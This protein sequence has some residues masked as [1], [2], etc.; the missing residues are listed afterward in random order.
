M[1]E[2]ER[3]IVIVACVVA[4]FVVGNYPWVCDDA[5]ISLRYAD[6]LARGYGL[7]FNPGERVQGFTNPLWTLLLVPGAALGSYEPWAVG[8]GLACTIGLLH[9]LARLARREDFGVWG[10][11]FCLAAT[12][13]CEGFIQFQTSGLETSLVN[14]LVAA[15]LVAALAADA[16]HRGLAPICAALACLTRLD[17]ALL[18]APIVVVMSLDAPGGWRRGLQRAWLGSALAAGLVLAWLGFAAIYYGYPLPNTFYAKTGAPRGEVLELGLRYLADF[19]ILR[20]PTTLIMIVGLACVPWLWRP[21]TPDEPATRDQRLFGAAAL[22]GGLALVYVVWVG[23]D[24]MHGRFVASPALMLSIVAARRLSRSP[25]RRIY[26]VAL[27]LGA[28]LTSV[29]LRPD[30]GPTQITN[31]RKGWPERAID[32][33]AIERVEAL[34]PSLDPTL[35]THL[36]GQRFGEDPR[37]SWLDSY[38][39]TDAF[40]ARCPIVRADRA[41]HFERAIPLAY[42]RAR[43]DASLLSAGERRLRAGDPSLAEALAELRANPGWD[44]RHEQ[45]YAELELLTRGPVWDPDRLALIAKYTLSRPT[46]ADIAGVETT[47]R[48]GD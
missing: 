34:D 44:P 3:T 24:Y 4:F 13:L 28:A 18:T 35:A 25:R 41:G 5:T 33:A 2:R 39:L 10:L 20:A 11:G 26:L 43:G 7:V 16:R 19:A 8:L 14:L 37:I 21:A 1:S 42:Y 40:I 9:L 31:E 47:A 15:T 17:S 27:A 32:S 46:V 30:T 38:G 23:G 22:G 29:A 36:V 6:N 48:V 45:I 12:F